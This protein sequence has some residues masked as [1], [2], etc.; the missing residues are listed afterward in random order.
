MIGAAW[1]DLRS[2][3]FILEGFDKRNEFSAENQKV[4]E[5]LLSHAFRSNQPDCIES[6]PSFGQPI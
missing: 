6:V 3:I 2:L 4:Y 1:N 5:E